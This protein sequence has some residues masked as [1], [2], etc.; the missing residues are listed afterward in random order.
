MKQIPFIVAAIFLFIFMGITS[1]SGAT[2]INVT[3]T[4]DS[5]TGVT[6]Y[7]F[8]YSVSPDMAN[9]TWH[10]A[11]EIPIENPALSFSMVCTNVDIDLFQTNYFA[12]AA[13][14]SDSEVF[15]D[16]QTIAATTPDTMAMVQDFRIEITDD[17]TPTSDYAINFQPATAPVPSGFLADSSL[18]YNVTRGYG[19]TQPPSSLGERDRNNPLSPDQSYDTMIHVK[20]EAI[21]EMAIA[22]GNYRVTLCMGDPS[23]PGG[24]PIVQAEG[25][26]IISGQTLTT[27]NRWIEESSEVQVADGRLTITFTGSTDPARICWV[28]V[29]SL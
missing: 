11:C 22:N 21:W 15:S 24:T 25:T 10:Q 3:W 16:T 29:N 13:I 9:K 14:T 8:Y 12:I 20:P 6:G 7:K 2:N 26:T 18:S 5:T 19:W 4:M 28:K 23:Y 17:S 1:S 27:S